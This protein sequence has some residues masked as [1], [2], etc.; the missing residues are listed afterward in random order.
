M[1]ASTS[2]STSPAASA[3]ASA[4]A[5]QKKEKRK[6]ACQ[7]CRARRI[8]CE[9]PD[10]GAGC[11]A[12]GLADLRCPGEPEPRKRAKKSDGS[13]VEVGARSATAGGAG[14]LSNA[15]PIELGGALTFH[16]IEAHFLMANP[17]IPG[18][19]YNL[20][21]EL[22][23]SAGGSSRELEIAA[24]CLC[25]AFIASAATFSDHSSIVGAGVIE[26]PV[27]LPAGTGTTYHELVD[28]GPRR[29]S[30][31]DMLAV[32][33]V[34]LYDECK[35]AER[36]SVE[37]IY[38][39]LA[40][41]QMSTLTTDG[42]RRSRTYVD[43]AILQFKRLL[44]SHQSLP[45]EQVAALRGP[46]GIHLLKLDAET[47]AVLKC[48]CAFNA[49]DVSIY[50]PDIG[51]DILTLP[52]FDPTQLSE[53]EIGWTNL[54]TQLAPLSLM[55]CKMYRTFVTSGGSNG[56]NAPTPEELQQLWSGIDTA[57]QQLDI[58]D[59]HIKT[60]PE[61]EAKEQTDLRQFD[62]Y[63][64]TNSCRRSAIKLDLLLHERILDSLQ[65]V[66]VDN[67][68]LAAYGASI[69][70]IKRDFGIVANIAQHNVE[71]RSLLYARRL[72]EVLEVCSAWTSLRLPTTTPDTAGTLIEEL[73]I[74]NVRVDSIMNAL[75]L[76]SWSSPLAAQEKK[77]L[78]TG[79]QFLTQTKGPTMGAVVAPA[80]PAFS[81]SVFPQNSG[82]VTAPPFDVPPLFGGAPV[83]GFYDPSGAAQF[84]GGP[85]SPSWPVGT[86]PSFL[87]QTYPGA[88]VGAPF[89]PSP[90]FSGIG[91]LSGDARSPMD[92]AQMMAF[93]NGMGA[94]SSA[95]ASNL[96]TG[97]APDYSSYPAVDFSTSTFGASPPG[98]S[99]GDQPWQSWSA[100]GGAGSS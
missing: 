53:H 37:A 36:P 42:G 45:P 9:W 46:L 16:L 14:G 60:L 19:P 84:A 90:G 23:N 79:I 26:M 91:G 82:A 10:S 3:S 11:I 58:A 29:R 15:P 31:V 75:D 77:G 12:C 55:F 99:S 24:E 20:Y 94:D 100:P 63:G 8:R 41:D 68:L 80:V 56:T 5:P 35:I 83:S 21:R 48:S 54:G 67:N 17:A 95:T 44:D 76:A 73:G 98:Q 50:F 97:V 85:Q 7:A 27:D 49:L 86:D 81:S 52:T 88:G 25:S 71:T 87:A 34:D 4:S 2:K 66:E 32:R 40:M 61:L 43:H 89:S 57:L 78:E 30:T 18:A 1:E 96:P 92:E 62:L 6:L 47:A 39:I 64:L 13:K 33:A 70:R 22:L 51:L 69:Q 74:P 28:Y 38:T 59:A 93:L 65:G 72:F